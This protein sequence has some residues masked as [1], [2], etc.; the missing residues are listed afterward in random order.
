MPRY[1]WSLITTV[2]NPI[3]RADISSM[4]I[5]AAMSA[6]P[7]S[8]AAARRTV[9]NSGRMIDL[10]A[11]LVAIYVGQT[12]QADHRREVV[13]EV[14]VLFG[15]HRFRTNAHM[16]VHLPDV[17]RGVGVAVQRV[18][19]RLHVR[20]VDRSIDQVVAELEVL[21]DAG[22]GLRAVEVQLPHQV[23]L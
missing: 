12:S 13:A 15:G 2:V 8:S 17:A 23:W 14:V 20:R 6:M 19:Q 21:D 9:E 22:E 1:R 11:L 10:N 3:I 16:H 4:I 7:R 5:S 18:R